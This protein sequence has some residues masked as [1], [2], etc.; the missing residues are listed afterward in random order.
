MK[1]I[2]LAGGR[3]TRLYPIT[4][5]TVKQLLPIYDKPL[6]YYPLSTLMLAGV[7]DILIISHKEYIPLY[8]DL[9]GDGSHLG[10]KL[11]Y[12]IQKEPKGLAEAF[13]V[14]EN[15]IKDESVWLV[16]G[17]NLFF[18]DHL[19]DMLTEVSK[20]QEGATVFAYKVKDPERYG[21]IEFD[22]NNNVLSIEEKPKEPKSDY[23]QTGLYFFD[24]DVASVAKRQ[25][26]SDRGE[27]E[28]VDTVKEYLKNGK[29]K[30]ERMGSGFAWLDT[31]TYDSMYDATSFVRVMQKRQ[32]IIISSPE[33]IAYKKGYIDK[34]QLRKLAKDLEQT[35]YGQHLLNLTK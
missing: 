23:A 3:G 28:I 19:E 29:L 26:Y 34:N 10:I 13:I 9:F 17:D 30:V 11:S 24:K 33:E 32:N 1:G 16:L 21:V 25:S 27:L 31:G 8:I 12:A 7:K 22:E 2:I 14:G 18:G 35:E 6:I 20:R 15:F 5:P 4:I